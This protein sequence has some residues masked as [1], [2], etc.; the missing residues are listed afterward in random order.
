M[1]GYIRVA[2]VE[3]TSDSEVLSTLHTLCEQTGLDFVT[4]SEK[5]MGLL[6]VNEQVTTKKGLRALLLYISEQPNVLWT[7]EPAEREL[8]AF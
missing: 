5:R 2:F 1:S 3:G 4:W 7:E 8:R 6:Y